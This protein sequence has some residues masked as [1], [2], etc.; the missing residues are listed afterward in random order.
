M[1]VSWGGAPVDR[2]GVA[3]AAASEAEQSK[4]R[5]GEYGS[6]IP[7]IDLHI[8]VPTEN[9]SATWVSTMP[10]DRMDSEISRQ[11]PAQGTVR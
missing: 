3:I 7:A 5:H 10:E 2:P 8:G 1:A 9:R 4:Y 6:R 11:P